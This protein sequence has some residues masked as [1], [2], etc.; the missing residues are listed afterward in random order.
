MKVALAKTHEIDPGDGKAVVHGDLCIAIF[1]DGGTY[2]AVNNVCPHA[3]GPLV[4]GPIEKGRIR[5]PWHGWSFPLAIEDAPN[6]GLPR[7]PLTIDGDA[8]LVELPD[9]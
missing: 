1:N 2:Y 6:D 8:I 5:C 7:Y 9:D 4:E 3:A